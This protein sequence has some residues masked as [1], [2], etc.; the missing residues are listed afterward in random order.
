MESVRQAA[1]VVMADLNLN[2]FELWQWK[3]YR[4]CRH[5]PLPGLTFST[6][7][8]N[9]F[10]LW[11]N[12]EQFIDVK[13][14]FSFSCLLFAM[15]STFRISQNSIGLKGVKGGRSSTFFRSIII[16]SFWGSRLAILNGIWSSYSDFHTLINKINENNLR[17]RTLTG[18]ESHKNSLKLS[19]P[20]RLWRICIYE[21]LCQSLIHS[22]QQRLRAI[23][24]FKQFNCLPNIKAIFSD[25]KEQCCRQSCFFFHV[26]TSFYSSI[27]CMRTDVI[28]NH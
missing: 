9:I 4:L 8:V 1:F 11:D 25:F 27:N 20:S 3:A 12:F 6:H 21:E 13:V 17:V 22:W 18:W 10:F 26:S 5:V 15:E 28:M 24:P 19:W 14:T 7:L 2:S 16:E 23:A